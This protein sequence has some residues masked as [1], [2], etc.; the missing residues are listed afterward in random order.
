MEYNELGDSRTDSSYYISR[1]GQRIAPSSPMMQEQDDALSLILARRCARVLP[2]LP[3]K[4]VS[5]NARAL[6]PKL[7]N[8]ASSGTR[9]RP[10]GASFHMTRSQ[11]IMFLSRAAC[12]GTAD[13]AARVSSPIDTLARPIRSIPSRRAML[14]RCYPYLCLAVT[15]V[16]DN[17]FL[18]RGHTELWHGWLAGSGVRI[19]P[20]ATSDELSKARGVRHWLPPC[21]AERQLE[22]SSC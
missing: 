19:K 14:T 16:P 21:A 7:K 5:S 8:K 10:T 18:S 11:Q 3:G 6:A 20:P 4:G 22:A 2:Q 1:N 17:P 9:L 13:I 12:L 15:T